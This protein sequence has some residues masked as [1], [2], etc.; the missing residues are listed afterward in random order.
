[1]EKGKTERAT[2]HAPASRRVS[3]S[4][5]IIFAK[6]PIAGQVKTRLC[7]P[8]TPDEAASLHGSFV[9]DALERSKTAIAK[10]RLP[11][12]RYLACAPSARHVFFQ[13]LEERHRVTL[14]DQVGENLGARMTYAFSTIFSSG[15]TNA[16]LVGTDVPSLPLDTYRDAL[17]LLADHDL[18]LGPASDG[19]YYLIGLKR[20]APELF[21]HIPWS[22]DRVFDLTRRK[23]DR[24]ELKTGLLP[25]QRDIDTIDDLL[26][27]IEEA[28][29]AVSFLSSRTA[30][31]LRLIGNRLR[32]R[33]PEP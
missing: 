10:H 26:P 15:Y 11:L 33:S 27:L 17:A 18:V 20:P 8:L 30:G 6:A 19:G 2:L 14:L 29:K 12:D 9:L 1:M 5:L 13:I 23:A 28:G 31:A 16:L 7:P 22:T 21:A 4:A 25:V 24:L 3:D 32:S